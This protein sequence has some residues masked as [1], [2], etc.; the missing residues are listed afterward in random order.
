MNS[1]FKRNAMIIGV[2]IILIGGYVLFGLGD[3]QIDN[4]ISGS[5][6]IN[7]ETYSNDAMGRFSANATYVEY[8]STRSDASG[9]KTFH[10]SVVIEGGDGTRMTQIVYRTKGAGVAQ[11]MMVTKIKGDA[12]FVSDSVILIG[13]DGDV[14]LDSVIDMSGDNVTFYGRIID[15]TTGK[16]LV[17]DR[18]TGVGDWDVWKR[19]TVN[20]I[21]DDEGWLEFCNKIS[22]ELTPSVGVKLVPINDTLVV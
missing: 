22:D 16:P 8:S 7:Q 9:E 1:T 13:E 19:V 21:K 3:V 4:R 15:S 11:E 10:Q 20:D 5:G 6:K 18:L 2:L 14:S 17:T 12:E